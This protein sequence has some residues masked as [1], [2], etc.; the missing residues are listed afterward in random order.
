[1][2]EYQKAKENLFLWYDATRKKSEESERLQ[3][4]DNPYQTELNSSISSIKK[5]VETCTEYE[6]VW[7]LARY[8]HLLSCVGIIRKHT[9]VDDDTPL[10]T[11]VEKLRTN[12]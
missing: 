6:G 1:M 12:P 3:F 9:S 5:A 8:E 2:D 7:K 11:L 4:R 10:G